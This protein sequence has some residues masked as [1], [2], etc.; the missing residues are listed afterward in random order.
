MFPIKGAISWGKFPMNYLKLRPQAAKGLSSSWT[1]QERTYPPFPGQKNDRTWPF[2]RAATKRSAWN[3]LNLYHLH[4]IR[5][6]HH[7][8]PVHY[9]WHICHIPHMPHIRHIHL[10]CHI[11]QEPENYQS[12]QAGGDINGQNKRL[13]NSAVQH[14]HPI[15]TH[16]ANIV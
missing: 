15:T 6:I 14:M 12:G 4:R 5:H 2:R 9:I 7:I 1:V 3:R 10:I 16:Y 13:T 8:H 11:H